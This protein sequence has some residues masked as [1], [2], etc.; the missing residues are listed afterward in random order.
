MKSVNNLHQLFIV[1]KVVVKENDGVNYDYSQVK[2]TKARGE[3]CERCWNIVETVN[4][5]HVCHRCESILA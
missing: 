2:I 1:S 3:R 4:E 5:E